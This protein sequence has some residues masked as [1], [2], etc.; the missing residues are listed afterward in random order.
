MDMRTPLGKV[1]GLGS[2]KEGTDHFWR[3]RLTAVA[4]VPLLLFFVIFLMIYAG[5]PYAEVVH[6][7]SNPIV[8][9][10]FGLMVISA[11]FH[12]RI[13]MQVIIEDY[14]HG[15]FAKIVLLMLNTFFAIVVAGLCLF[16]VLKIAFV[17]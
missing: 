9:V 11:L 13:G 17:G 6:A 4:N 8:A 14:V 7:L 12:M 5:A 15:E 16:A 3:Q 2:A 1:R 10:I